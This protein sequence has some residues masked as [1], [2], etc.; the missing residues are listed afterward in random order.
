MTYRGK[1]KGG[2]VVLEAGARLDEGAEVV[3]EA[4]QA[5]PARSLADR[6][7]PVIG[8]ATG[9]PKDLARNHDHYLHGRPKASQ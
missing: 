1:V 4:V 3:V 8:I 5:L 9:L 7:K 2:V 6:L